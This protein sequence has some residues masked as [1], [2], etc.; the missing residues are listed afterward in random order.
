MIDML[1]CGAQSYIIHN[2]G[3]VELRLLWVLKR[4]IERSKLFNELTKTKNIL[5]LKFDDLIPEELILFSEHKGVVCTSV[6]D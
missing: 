4:T 6:I 2:N 5:P 1:K 3:N